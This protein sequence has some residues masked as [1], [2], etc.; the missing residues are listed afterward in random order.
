MHKCIKKKTFDHRAVGL[1][2]QV[3]NT[4]LPRQISVQP[5]YPQASNNRGRQTKPALGNQEERLEHLLAPHKVDQ[6]AKRCQN[7]NITQLSATTGRVFFQKGGINNW[8]IF[9]QF[10]DHF[11]TVGSLI[12]ISKRIITCFKFSHLI[13]MQEIKSYSF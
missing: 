13:L 1:L 12:G 9:C 3:K 8:W 2:S 5:R 7:I 6:V 4:H 10:E 11:C